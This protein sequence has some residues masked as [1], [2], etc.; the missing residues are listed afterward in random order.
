MDFRM[1]TDSSMTILTPVT[2]AAKDW[3][4]DCLPDDCPMWGRDGYAIE[5]N[6]FPPIYSG[7]VN[8]GFDIQ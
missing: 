8:A 3:C 1:S 7:I 5:N 2:K 4:N 6:Y